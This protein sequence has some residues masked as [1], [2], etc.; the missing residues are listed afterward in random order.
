MVGENIKLMN[1]CEEKKLPNCLTNGYERFDNICSKELAIKITVDEIVNQSKYCQHLAI[2]IIKNGDPD[3]YLNLNDH[4][5]GLKN[6]VGLYHLW[7]ELDHCQD[8]DLYTMLCVYVGKGHVKKRVLHHIKQKW[9]EQQMLHVTFYECENR[10]AKYLEQLFL[11]TYDYYLNKEENNGTEYLY[12]HWNEDRLVMGTE[13]YTMA[14][15][16]AKKFMSD[17]Q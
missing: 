1:E 7:I 12:A 3:E 16:Y 4:L 15:V 10:V 14:D 6:K 9:P 2:D 5:S 17:H 11:D 8:H 13:L